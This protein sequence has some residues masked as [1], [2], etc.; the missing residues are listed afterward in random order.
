M[1]SKYEQRCFIKVQIARSKNAR[2][3][4]I[5]LLEACLETL[6]YRTVFRWAYAFSRGRED[7]HQYHTK[8]IAVEQSVQRL[9]Q[10]DAVDGIRCLPD[11]WMRVLHVGRDYS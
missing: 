4:Y 2:Q 5:E 8:I 9:G 11:V 3:C 6:S 1:F 7:V 10:Q